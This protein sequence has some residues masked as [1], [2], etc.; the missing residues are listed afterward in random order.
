[1]KHAY[2]PRTTSYS[3][4]PEDELNDLRMSERVRPL[5]DH[6]GLAFFKNKFGPTWEPRYLVLRH[7]WDLPAAA[8]AL[9]RLHLG[10]S[11]PRVISSVLAGLAPAR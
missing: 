5:Y 3:L 7:W 9:L 11:W 6:E 2:V 10:G 4:N 1:M 8:L